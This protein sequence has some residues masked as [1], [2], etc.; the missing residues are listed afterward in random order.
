MRTP[1]SNVYVSMMPSDAV[2]PLADAMVTS[3]PDA[4]GVTGT[5]GEAGAFASA[6]AR[7]TGASLVVTERQRIYRL[8][9]VTVPEA[10]AGR[11]RAAGSSDRDLLVEWSEAFEIEVGSTVPG[12]AAGT[13]DTRLAENR[14]FVWVDG[15]P[16]CYAGTAGP[17]GGVVRIGPVYTPPRHRKRGYAS[18]LVAAASQHALENGAAA[19]SLYTDLANPTSNKIYQAVGY[20]PVCDV[21]MYQFTT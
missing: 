6:W 17:A 7:R 21:A 11:W 19:C 8:D 4:G 5:A 2:E 1:P 14:A 18:A 10:P 13:V 3:C 12:S 9:R 20:R 15:V 16:V